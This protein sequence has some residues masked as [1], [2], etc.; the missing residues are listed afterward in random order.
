MGKWAQLKIPTYIKVLSLICK[1]GKFEGICYL[2]TTESS[3]YDR[4][5]MLQF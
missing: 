3:V 2:I 4:V 5:H 1:E